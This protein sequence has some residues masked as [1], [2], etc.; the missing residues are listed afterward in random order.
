MANLKTTYAQPLERPPFNDNFPGASFW[1]ME[2]PQ[3]SNK[4]ITTNQAYLV[5]EIILIR[6]TSNRSFVK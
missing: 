3:M 6:C 5:I 2:M 4:I 1:T